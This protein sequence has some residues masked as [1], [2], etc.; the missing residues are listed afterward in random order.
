V[1]DTAS[2]RGKKHSRHLAGW[3]TC[4]FQQ[5]VD[6]GPIHG[7][8]NSVPFSHRLGRRGSACRS[9]SPAS[10][11]FELR[12]APRVAENRFIPGSGKDRPELSA[13]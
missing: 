8:Q 7:H 5:I 10:Q 12:L 4:L 9:I 6:L 1:A 3:I 11:T 13:R 2:R